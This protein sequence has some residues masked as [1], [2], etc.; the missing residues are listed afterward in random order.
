MHVCGHGFANGVVDVVEEYAGDG[1]V[2]TGVGIIR[3]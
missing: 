3:P 2:G 1:D